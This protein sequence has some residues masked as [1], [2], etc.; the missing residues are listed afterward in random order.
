ML[1]KRSDQRGLFEADHLYLDLVGRD[2]FY[3]RLAGLRGQLFRD[4]DFAALYCRDNG[5]S[6]VPPSLLATALLLQA[7]DKVSD[8]EAH[9]RATVDLSWKVAL[10]VEVEVR[11]FAQST[12]QHFRA[13][14]VLHAQMRELFLR[15]LELARARG[16]LRGRSLQVALDTTPIWGRGAV[17]DTY[18]LLADGIRQLLRTL[19][20]VQ[21]RELAAW[22]AGQGYARYL[23]AS[24]KG[25]A[26]ID[27]DQ[28]TAREA[29][30]AEIVAD[31]DRLLAAARHAQAGCAADSPERG[32][33][34]AAAQLLGQ[35][36]HQDVARPAA[37]VHLKKGVSQDRIVSV[38]DPEMRHGRK[39]SSQRFDGHKAAVAVDPRPRGPR[40]L[41]TAVAVLPG[42]APD[43]QG[44]LQLVAQSE[45]HTGLPVTAAIADAAYG[46]GHTR[47]QFADAGRTLIAKVRKR[48]ARTH[49]PKEDF[50][51]DLAA[52]TCTCP[53]GQVTRTVRRH[54]F[55][56]TATGAQAPRRSFH[57]D[58]ALCTACP[59]RPRCVVA[60]PGR[61]RQVSLHPQ[62]ALLQ[63]ARTLQHSAAFAPYRHLRQ[64]V[65][66]R[67]ARLV[68]LGLRQAR[69][70]G[71]HKTATQ[72]YLTATVANLTR[73]LAAT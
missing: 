54:G 16:L 31:A 24:V 29:F 42:N 67:L 25:T 69:Y 47:Q 56:A 32:R 45:Q 12:L 40:Q 57:F 6:S 20:R 35:L 15:S 34:V 41:I 2:S 8:A 28:P 14:L 1:G 43:A 26:E 22:A 36:L 61:G 52:V 66:H 48:P 62:S 18:N 33:I 7:Y 55:Y 65:E 50:Q 38:H 10:G 64:A 9:R 23:A 13:Q 19:A 53:A 11:P 17:K 58:A 37:G 3:G 27:W 5:R 4:K 30:L 21:D 44:A 73:I 59:L 71:R 63:A 72:L 51:I 70:L 46:D 60:A 49:F 68:Q 39:S